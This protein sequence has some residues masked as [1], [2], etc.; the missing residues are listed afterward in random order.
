MTRAAMLQRIESLTEDE[1]ER[2]EPYLAADLDL[3]AD[4]PDLRAEIER[5]LES[6]LTEPLLDHETVMAMGRARLRIS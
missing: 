2:V 4:L 3:A 6:A 5:G 1:F